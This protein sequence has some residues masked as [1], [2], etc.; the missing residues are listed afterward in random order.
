MINK[1]PNGFMS[2]SLENCFENYEKEEI[3]TEA[4]Q[5]FCNNCFQMTNTLSRNKILTCPEVI[6]IILNRGKALQFDVIFEYPLFLNIDR[7]VMDESS[8][9]NFKYEL[10][11]V[12]AHIGQSLIAEHFIAFCKSPVNDKWY[13]YNDANVSEIDDPRNQS[14]DIEGIPYVLFY[15]KCDI[16]KVDKINRANPSY[17]NQEYNNSN[18]NITLYINYNDKQCLLDVNKND[19][20][21]NIIIN[22]NKKYKTPK[23]AIL[24]LLKDNNFIDLEDNK[25]I[26]SYNIKDQ[27]ILTLIENS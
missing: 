7:F 19:K 11:C 25:T 16:N 18:N 9:G 27:T 2:V 12:I 26:D 17:Q 14:S 1:C 4:N 15:Q 6:T 8:L 22:L 23:N 3:L 10:I 21:R 5:M 24:Y 20:I 13:C